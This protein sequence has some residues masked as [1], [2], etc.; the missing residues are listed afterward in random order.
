MQGFGAG[1]AGERERIK[2]KGRIGIV[3]GSLYLLA[4]RWPDAVKELTE[5]ATIARAN[6]DYLWHGKALDY[7]AICL[8]MYAWAG[9][10]FRVSLQILDL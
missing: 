8:V 3:I 2:G 1:G 10:E 9:M 7:L 6:T 5:G 4:G